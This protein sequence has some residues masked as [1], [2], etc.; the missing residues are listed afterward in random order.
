MF[1]SHEPARKFARQTAAVYSGDVIY[2]FRTNIVPLVR[3]AKI[4]VQKAAEDRTNSLGAEVG[5]ANAIATQLR[6]AIIEGMFTYRERMPSERELAKRFGAAR[7]TIRSALRQLEQMNLVTRRAGSGSF[8]CYR[9][10]ADHEDIT[11]LTSPLELIDVRIAIEPAMARLAVANAN[12]Q[13]LD[14]MAEVLRRL[15]GCGSDPAAF[16]S[17]DEAFHMSLAESA[18]NPLMLWLYRHIN[19]VRGHAQWTARKDKVLT[20][21][22]IVQ[23]NRQHRRVFTAISRRDVE[24]A[25]RALREHLAQ[26]RSDLLGQ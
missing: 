14:R 8:V 4:N 22:K 2:Q 10:H 25:E 13:D 7:G 15:E 9:G 16:S 19:E 26:A 1:Y 18:R 6:S 5:G 21:P 11:E 12:A 20:P 23:Y 3:N 24:E 17:L